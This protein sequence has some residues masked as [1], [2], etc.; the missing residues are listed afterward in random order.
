M[1]S[2]YQLEDPR[3]PWFPWYVG[4]GKESRSEYHWRHFLRR[5]TAV[6][7][8][9]RRWFEFLHENSITP[10][11]RIIDCYIPEDN[12]QPFEVY[13]ISLARELNP[14]L[15]NVFDGGNNP[16]ADSKNIGGWR[17]AWELHPDLMRSSARRAAAQAWKFHPEL[18]FASLSRA[19]RLGGKRT[20]ELHADLLRT[21]LKRTWRL[22]RELMVKSAR[23]G[24]RL[25]AHN[26][27]HAA[28][29]I[30][31]PNCEFCV[32]I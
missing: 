21:K 2:I 12:W 20:G 22:Q 17:R 14:M 29:G 16:F 8:K 10:Y 9:L 18:K 7:G 30:I 13:Y 3:K 31:N 4:K 25:G 11:A 5:R 15:C 27:W 23:K 24:G 28:R 32:K 26:R 1:T 6:N 19:G